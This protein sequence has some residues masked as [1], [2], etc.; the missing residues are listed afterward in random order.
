MRRLIVITLLLAVPFAA[1]PRSAFAMRAEPLRAATVAS[2]PPISG[3]IIQRVYTDKA[4]YAPNTSAVISAELTNL[5]GASWTGSVALNV[6]HL[7]ASVYTASQ[8]V[9]LAANASQTVTFTWA[10]PAT[11]FQGYL[12]QVTAGTIDY[13]ATAIDVSSTWTRYPRYGY[14]DQFPSGE[15]SAQS[16]TKMQDLE[17]DYH[18]NAVQF[19]DWMW[20]HEQLIQRT[21]GVMNSTWTDWSGKVISSQVLQNQIAAAHSLNQAAM[22]YSMV[23]GALNNYQS[24]SGVDPSWGMYTD[25]THTNQDR[26]DFGPGFPGASMYLFDPDNPDWQN[27]I[28]NQYNDAVTTLGFDGMHLDQLGQRDGRYD[29]SGNALDLGNSFSPLMQ[30]TRDRLPSSSVVTYNVVNPGVGTWAEYNVARYGGSNFD[31]AELWDNTTT[32]QNLKDTTAYLRAQDGNKGVVLPGYMNYYED[33][34]TRLEAETATLNGVTTNTNHTGYTGTGFVD[35]F[36]AV[37]SYVQ[38]SITAPEAGNYALV[39]RYANATGATATRDVVVDGTTLSTLQFF[40]QANWDTWAYDAYAVANLTAGTHAVKLL[41]SASNSTAINLDNLVL[42][43]FEPNSVRLADAAIAAAGASHIEMGPG[44]QMLAHPFFSNRSK[45]MRS[46]L[47]TAMKDHY[48]FITGYENLLYDPAVQNVDSGTQFVT[49]TGQPTSASAAAGSIWTYRKRSAGYELVHFINLI[50]NNNLWRYSASTPGTLTN[51]ATKV[52]VGPDTTV[53]GVYV[54]SPD[55]DH[56]ASTSLSYTTG[57]DANG[58]YVSFTM[59][60]LQY[61]NLV[62]IK[63]SFTAPAGGRYEAERALKTGVTT[64]TNHLGYT[65]TGFV[66]GF[67]AV[68]SGVSFT[69]TA[70]AD[71]SYT[72]QFRYANA[73]GSAATRTVAVDGTSVGQSSFRTLWNW[74]IWATSSVTTHLSAGTH[75]VVLWLGSGDATALNLDSL[76]VVERTDPSTTSTASLYVSNWQDELAMWMASKL[77]QN[78]T[79]TFGPRIGEL[80]YSGAWATNQIVDYSGFFRDESNALKYTQ[81]HNFDSEGWFESD[82]TVTTNYL[83]YSGAATAMQVSRNYAFPP[84]QSF[85]V[86]KYTLTNPTAASLTYNLLDNVHANNLQKSTTNMHGW[87]D[88]TRNTLFIDMTGSGQYVLF[89]GA[90][91]TMDSHQVGND[92]DSVVTDATAAPWY[93]FDNNGT[94]RNNGDIVTPDVDLAFQKQFAVAAGATSSAGF[95][96]GVRPTIVAAQ[97]AADIAR[98][99]T[100]AYWFSQT[101]TAA[102]AWLNGGRRTTFADAGLNN[103]YDRSLLMMKNTQRPGQAWP[104]TT[105]PASYSYKVWVRDSSITAISLDAA[106]HTAEA[107]TFWRWMALVQNVDGTWHTNYDLWSNNWISFVEPEHDAIGTFLIGA[108]RH[109]QL[110]GDRSFLDAVWPQIQLS[111]N[112]VL[113]NIG[114]NGFGPADHSIWEEDLEYNSFTQALYVAGLNAAAQAAKVEGNTTLYDNW[115]GGPGTITTALQKSFLTSPAGMFNSS[116]RYFDRAVTTA[117]VSR[118]WIDSSSNALFVFGALDAGSSRLRDHVARIGSVLTHDTWGIAR[119][120]GD[121]YYYTSPYSPAGNEALAAEPSWPQMS[122][123]AAIWEM[124]SGRSA[125]ALQR[126]QWYASRS[127]KGWVAPGEAVSNVS[128]Q[129]IVSTMAEPLTAAAYIITALDYLGLYAPATI[130]RQYNAGTNKSITVSSGTTGDW[131]QWRDVSYFLDVTGDASAGGSMTDIRKVYVTN[132]SSNIYMRVDNVSGAL[133]GYATEPKFAMFVYA[134]DYNHSG[135]VPALTTGYFGGTLDRPMQY[136]V[137]RWSD[138][139]SFSRFKVVSGAWSFDSNITSVIAPQWDATRG[140]IE[141]VIPISSLTSSGSV[142]LGAWANLNVALAYHNAVTNV[143]SDADLLAIHYRLTDATTSAIVGNLER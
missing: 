91:Q 98:A 28:T 53:S 92:A 46:A 100:V 70:P 79:G 16:T 43:T 66:D 9:T 18:I 42:G 64:N 97:S 112:F 35:G 128:R 110:T 48:N 12:V 6:L 101:G 68:N 114:S 22:A 59:P 109:Y 26:F 1:A 88:A 131:L 50:G 20:R 85:L 90:L 65:G 73:T 67:S 75:S 60:A 34:G 93:T 71:D 142:G 44:G 31:Y 119:Y 27:Y 56:G 133:S 40:N 137:G 103:A 61:W 94:L 58:T 115:T 4:R 129:P 51:L 111:A 14:T 89:L 138:S 45:Q 38:F 13:G 125:D 72:L 37:G 41:F 76:T 69:I 32:F 77:N 104:A 127:G 86:S 118:Q 29:Y 83:N 17:R 57:S 3:Q 113:N 134:E 124:Q 10:P 108:W 19:Y 33:A 87:Y 21:G 54:A 116:N 8:G 120:Q 140:R 102:S 122:M 52:Y 63:R 121:A 11:D 123:Y 96:I 39:F 139:G 105:N 143:W 7:E 24:V 25:A 82:G 141:M 81:I 99:Q 135:T 55:R 36:T 47:K 130:A 132:D 2:L 62:S 74:D 107:D 49:V 117:N 106:G 80:H 78:D 30:A 126:L 23:Y 5:T 15:S 95:F 136:L 84:N